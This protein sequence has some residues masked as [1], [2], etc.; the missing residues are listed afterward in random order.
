MWWEVELGG[1]SA[2][3]VRR[4][5]RNRNTR[6]QTKHAQ[7]TINT[8]NP[9]P[10]YLPRCKKDSKKK[11]LTLLETGLIVL[12]KGREIDVHTRDLHTLVINSRSHESSVIELKH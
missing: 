9:R 3:V 2:L 7:K 11:I 4:R 8:F 6:P 12:G 1:A 5:D 10:T